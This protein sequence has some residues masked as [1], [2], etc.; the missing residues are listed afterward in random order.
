MTVTHINQGNFTP[1]K[2]YQAIKLISLSPILSMAAYAAE[3]TIQDVDFYGSVRV[4]VKS[5][6]SGNLIGFCT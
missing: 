3:P 2:F 5:N 6:R 1:M 4:G